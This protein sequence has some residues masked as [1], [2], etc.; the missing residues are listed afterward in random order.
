LLQLSSCSKLV[1]TGSSVIK[2]E[3]VTVFVPHAYLQN[4]VSV[5]TRTNVTFTTEGT[6]SDRVL[7]ENRQVVTVAA[8]D[9]PH[10][11]ETGWNPPREYRNETRAKKSLTEKTNTRTATIR[12]EKTD[13]KIMQNIY[14]K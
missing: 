14:N 1:S 10:P 8:V 7:V 13:R 11:V 3:R 2:I 9:V 6:D 12:V 5:I 4:I